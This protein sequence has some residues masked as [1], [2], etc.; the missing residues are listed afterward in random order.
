MLAPFSTRIDCALI[1]NN[2]KYNISVEG[3]G[4]KKK[5]GSMLCGVTCMKLRTLLL[6]LSGV[7]GADCGD[8]G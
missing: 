5:V 7:G 3:P 6:L 1:S 4:A 8:C 2:D